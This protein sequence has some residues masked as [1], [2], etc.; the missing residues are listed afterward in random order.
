MVAS[1]QINPSDYFIDNEKFGKIQ[2]DSNGIGHGHYIVS[3]THE[4]ILSED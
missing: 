1:G 4:Q 3:L 2:M